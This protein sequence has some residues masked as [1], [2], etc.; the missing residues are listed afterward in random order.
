MEARNPSSKEQWR[1]QRAEQHKRGLCTSSRF[2]AETQQWVWCQNPQH[3]RGR[4]Q[5]CIDCLRASKNLN[6]QLIAEGYCR[7]KQN[8]PVGHDC[9]DRLLREGRIH[10][11]T[12]EQAQ[13]YH[14]ELLTAGGRIDLTKS[15]LTSWEQKHLSH[16]IGMFSFFCANPPRNLAAFV[17]AYRSLNHIRGRL[18]RTQRNWLILGATICFNNFSNE[19][20]NLQ[21]KIKEK[22]SQ[23]VKDGMR[24]AALAGKKAGR[25]KKQRID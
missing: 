23:M 8:H 2:D 19:G 7:C 6:E 16:F 20:L 12:P 15:P 3:P 1:I 18:T 22:N 14:T 9:P 24:L 25:P 10:L 17:K 13:W 5:K 4:K 11:I 21:Q